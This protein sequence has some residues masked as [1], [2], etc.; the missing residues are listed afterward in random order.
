M[1]KSILITVLLV[2]VVTCQEE[3][4]GLFKKKCKENQYCYR[5]DLNLELD[6]GVCLNYMKKGGFCDER[7][8]CEPPLECKEM[9]NSFIKFKI[10]HEPSDETVPSTFPTDIPDEDTNAP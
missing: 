2:A 6:L 10:C 5:P 4:C 3:E 1:F 9:E 7:L 8:R